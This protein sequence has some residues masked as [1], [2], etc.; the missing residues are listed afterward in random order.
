MHLPMI[1][2]PEVVHSALAFPLLPTL[3]SLMLLPS[4]MMHASLMLLAL[5]VVHAQCSHL[6][7]KWMLPGF[8]VPVLGHYIDPLLNLRLLGSVGPGLAML[9]IEL[10]C[11]DSM[12]HG[13]VLLAPLLAEA[14]TTKLISPAAMQPEAVATLSCSASPRFECDKLD[15]VSG[16]ARSLCFNSQLFLKIPLFGDPGAKSAVVA[17]MAS[18]HI[19]CDCSS[20]VGA[21]RNLWSSCSTFGFGKIMFR[22]TEYTSA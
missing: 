4:P 9:L 5:Y 13:V 3:A 7:S 11:S 15:N 12:L 1:S 14:D 21:L 19:I 10:R 17:A 18:W 2:S 16:A 8:D 20:N 22:M 6:L